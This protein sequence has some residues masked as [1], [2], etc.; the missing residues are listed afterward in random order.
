M[1]NNFNLLIYMIIQSWPPKM[2]NIRWNLNN[3]N[4]AHLPEVLEDGFIDY[5][6]TSDLDA[7][8]EPLHDAS[9]RALHNIAF[10]AQCFVAMKTTSSM[11]NRNIPNYF[12]Q[13]KMFS[14]P[15][16]KVGRMNSHFMCCPCWESIIDP[17]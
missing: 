3:P 11:P 16:R 14:L 17:M 8:Q 15:A 4:P 13:L 9:S 6:T 1:N 2:K 12:M 7:Q 5:R 10:K